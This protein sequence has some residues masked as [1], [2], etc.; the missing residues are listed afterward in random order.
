LIS[1]QLRGTRA[2]VSLTDF[3]VFNL[4]PLILQVILV[5]GSLIYFDL[6]SAITIFCFII[7][8]CIYSFIILNKQKK[9]NILANKAVDYEKANLAD[10]F[11]NI[12]TV[13]Y[14]GK[15]KKVK[16]FFAKIVKATAQA[17]TKQWHYYRWFDA[18][19]ALI[20][21]IGFFFLMYFPTIKFINGDMTIGTLVFIY[22]VYGQIVGPLFN[23]VHGVRNFYH[24]MAD[25][26][27]LFKYDKVKNDIED[28]KNAPNLRVKH[29][30]IEFKDIT[31]AYSKR[32]ILKDFNLKIKPGERIALVG[33]SGCGK[34]TLMKLLYRLYD[35]DQGQILVD[36]KNIKEFKQESLR[37]EL[38]IVPQECILFD[39]TIFNNIL[40][41][42]AS[43]K[44]DE[45]LK[46]IKFAQLDRIIKTFPEKEKTIVGERGIKLSGGEKQRVSIARAILANKKIIVLDEATSSLDSE[47]EYEIQRSLEKLLKNRTSIIIAHRLSTIMNADRIIVMDKGKIV[48]IGDHNTLIKKQGQYKKLWNLQK[49][50][51]IK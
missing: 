38:S 45:V 25:F 32:K 30:N 14:F 34:T 27:E 23:F 4:S 36:G 22:A 51:Y 5:G 6:S 35:T 39:D 40:F 28:K 49:G 33:H 48:Q 1:A 2:L 43:A 12:E 24:A 44:K 8:F 26:D 50:G 31:F 10:I 42:R 41:S 46:A 18:G 19:H 20:L 9:Y 11:T 15:E 17:K 13:K 3:F 7:V 47:T 29:G 37:S 21:A 16:S